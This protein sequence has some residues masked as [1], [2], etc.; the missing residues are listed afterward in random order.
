MLHNLEAEIARRNL[1]K[2]EV[3]SCIGISTRT[4]YDKIIG[5]TAFTIREATKLQKELF[6]ECEMDYL[7]EQANE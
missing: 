5:K 4:L 1:T 2:Q 7:F 6:P 3:A